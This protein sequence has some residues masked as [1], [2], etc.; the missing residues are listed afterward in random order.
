MISRFKM[1]RTLTFDGAKK[2]RC[3]NCGHT[4]WMGVGEDGQ[5]CCGK[6]YH[7]FYDEH[8]D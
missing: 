5:S 7:Q 1:P 8:H 6:C 2:G 4:T 3:E